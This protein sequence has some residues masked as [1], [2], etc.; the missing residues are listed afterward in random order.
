MP[1]VFSMAR[2]RNVPGLETTAFVSGAAAVATRPR[3]SG[4]PSTCVARRSR[5]GAPPFLVRTAPARMALLGP[6]K[7]LEPLGDG[8]KALVAGGAGEPGVHLGVLVGL[9]LN[10][11]LQILLGR[12]DR[13]AGD[14]VADLC[15]VV[16]VAERMPGLALGD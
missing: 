7:R 5:T 16:E 11:G 10:G 12:P 15:E 6:G 2:R 4:R 1:T 8:F 13:N 3:R 14:R 9:A